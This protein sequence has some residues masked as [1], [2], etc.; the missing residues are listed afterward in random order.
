MSWTELYGESKRGVKQ[1]LGQLSETAMRLKELRENKKQQRTQ[2]LMN[3]GQLGMQGLGMYSGIKEAERGRTFAAGEA[4]LGREHDVALA[5]EKHASDIIME[6]TRA[7]NDMVQQEVA[8][9]K[10][11]RSLKDQQAFVRQQTEDAFNRQVQLDNAKGVRDERLER[12]KQEFESAQNNL[13]RALETERNRLMGRQVSLAEQ[14]EGVGTPSNVSAY[15]E[16]HFADWLEGN[17]RLYEKYASGQ[18]TE[19]DFNAYLKVVTGTG[20][21]E[22]FNFSS[23]DIKNATL[24]VWEGYGYEPPKPIVIDKDRDVGREGGDISRITGT[25]VG[26][27]LKQLNVHREM[28]EK[29]IIEPILKALGVRT[30]QAEGE[31]EQLLLDKINSLKDT[32]QPRMQIAG[33]D[34]GRKK[35]ERILDRLAK[36]IKRSGELSQGRL[37]EI[38]AQLNEISTKY[39]TAQ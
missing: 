25:F 23:E 4:K 17:P 27:P 14:K 33:F 3:L 5:K 24:A 26:E 32:I 31:Q 16:G 39:G 28:T 34:I 11:W 12:A 18:L 7:T 15:V 37:S 2:N 1:S 21:S 6:N 9:M 20:S 22:P 8:N 30:P 38:M 10:A 13:N 29:H 36:E 19:D 35:G